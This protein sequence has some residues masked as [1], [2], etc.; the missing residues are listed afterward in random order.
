[1]QD[2]NPI[3]ATTKPNTSKKTGGFELRTESLDTRR[4]IDALCPKRSQA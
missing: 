2:I 4:L 3:V 1:M